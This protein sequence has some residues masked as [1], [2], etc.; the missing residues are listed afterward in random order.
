MAGFGEL[1][2]K[3]LVQV[4]ADLR[5]ARNLSMEDLAGRAGLH[6]TYI[7]LLERGE[8]QP[9]VA[10]AAELCRALG[11]SLSEVLLLAE[12]RVR[13]RSATGSPDSPNLNA[14][15][16]EVIHRP[17]SRVL[18]P[19]SFRSDSVLKR[20]TGLTRE[21]IFTA[22][23]SAYHQFDLID[24]QLRESG[25]PPIAELFEL[26]NVSSMFGNLIS[27]ALAR[28]SAG[29]YAR[30]RPHAYPDLVPQQTGLPGLEIKM[31]LEKNMPKGHLAKA[32][33][34]ITLRYVLVGR[35]ALFQR[36]KPYRGTI[37]EIWEIRCGALSDVDFSI[38][39][40]PGDSGKTA[41]I[42]SAAFRGMELVYY[43]AKL[44]PFVREPR[45]H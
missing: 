21:S 39:N 23:E 2:G 24:E 33:V 10:T 27:S 19:D 34:Y 41:V 42:R 44:S 32:G 37:A 18:D 15:E 1:L 31:A 17:D 16:I 8:R 25:S 13:Q 45:L 14:P 28:A 40:T 30:N 26:A 20:L 7:G 5:R 3:A 9:T 35:D 11:T 38:S 36:G 12:E 6:R 29:S 4:L 22:A 43:A